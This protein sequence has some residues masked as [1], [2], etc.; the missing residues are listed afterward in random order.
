MLDMASFKLEKGI[1]GERGRSAANY[2]V[3]MYYIYVDILKKPF[4][5]VPEHIFLIVP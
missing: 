1:M 3:I 5:I 4:L 2:R